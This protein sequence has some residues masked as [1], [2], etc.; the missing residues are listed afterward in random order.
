METENKNQVEMGSNFAPK[1]DE[2]GLIPAIVQS[3]ATNE[4]LMLAYMNAAA[5]TKTL[6]TGLAHFWSRSRQSMWLKGETSGQIQHVKEINIDCD[7]DTLLLKVVVAGDRGCCHVGFENCFYRVVNSNEDG[8]PS[9][10]ITG[11][12]P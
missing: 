8:A 6:E 3:H 5:L 7:Q 10:V 11:K 1:Y 2:N 9:L 4:V 12:K